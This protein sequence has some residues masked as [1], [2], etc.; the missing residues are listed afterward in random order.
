MTLD[1]STQTSSAS[2]PRSTFNKS[3]E[4]FQE[5]AGETGED[6]LARVDL[7]PGRS[8]SDEVIRSLATWYQRIAMG[9]TEGRVH[10]FNVEGTLVMSVCVGHGPVSA[11]VADHRGLMA[12]YCAGLLTTFKD[13]D[14]SGCAKLPD[15][16][17][18]VAAHAGGLLVW[19][20]HTVWFVNR[21]GRVV[22]KAEFSKAVRSVIPDDV[23]FTVLAGHLFSFRYLLSTERSSA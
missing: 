16:Y 19:R 1:S 5:A 7:M 11:I 14:I 21:R 22:W 12:T 15:Y 13:N 10:V 20:W 2:A 18:S 23:G 17:A 9:T 3:I 4:V 6:V 8:G